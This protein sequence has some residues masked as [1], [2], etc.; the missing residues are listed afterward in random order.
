MRV[1]VCCN[2]IVFET[3]KQLVDLSFPSRIVLVGLF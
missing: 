1:V 3:R 2:L